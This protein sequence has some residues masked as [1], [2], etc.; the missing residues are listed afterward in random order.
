MELSDD[1]EHG[2]YLSEGQDHLLLLD[3]ECNFRRHFM[4][5]V[6]QLIH[7]DWYLMLGQEHSFLLSGSKMVY[8][9]QVAIT[10]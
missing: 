3:Q 6:Y 2:R 7:L 10:R 1:K 9:C 5:W 4:I 8:R